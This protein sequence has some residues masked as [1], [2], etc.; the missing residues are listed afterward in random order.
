MATLKKN[1]VF[2]P[3]MFRLA[4]SIVAER[5]YVLVIILAIL[6]CS[7]FSG[8]IKNIDQVQ[9]VLETLRYHD[10]NENENDKTATLHVHLAFLCIS[11][12]PCA[13]TTGKCLISHFME[14]VNKR[15]LN[16]LSL[17]EVEYDS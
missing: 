2:T 6:K 13:I 16:F 1:L 17:S 9:L 3:K 10:G 8:F 11:L 5:R 12:R 15:R 4:Q 7:V 14:D